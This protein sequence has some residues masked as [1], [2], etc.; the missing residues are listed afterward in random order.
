MGILPEPVP[1]APVTNLPTAT[2]RPLGSWWL[3][4]AGLVLYAAAV[5]AAGPGS[6]LWEPCLGIGLAWAAWQGWRLLPGFF[7]LGLAASLAIEGSHSLVPT[8]LRHLGLVGQLGVSWWLFHAIGK[9]RRNLTDPR[10]ATLFLILV[11]GLVAAVFAL[12]E[13]GLL[14]VLGSLQASV[15]QATAKTWIGRSLGLIALAPPLLGVLGPRLTDRGLV[16]SEG[17]PPPGGEPPTDWTWGEIVETS[18]LCLGAGILAM[19][20]TLLQV[21]RG[22]P[23]W[24]LWGFSLLLVV[25]ASV[26][27]GLRGG[28]LTALAAACAGLGTATLLGSLASEF[29]PLQGN[30]LA[31]GSTALLVGA[32]AGWIRASEARYRQVVGHIPVILYSARL[33]R[34]LSWDAIRRPRSNSHPGTAGIPDARL[35]AEQA[36]VT[37]VSQA[38]RSILGRAPEELLGPYRHW[39]DR[40]PEEDR[41]LPLA[42]LVQMFLQKQPVTA[43]YRVFGPPD[44]SGKGSLRWIR[45]TLTAYHAPNGMLDGWEGVLEDIT[46]QRA[47]AQEVRRSTGMLQGLVAN[48][49]T[50]VYFVQAPLGQPLL[51]NARARQLLGQREDPA[52]GISHL[53]RV[54]RLHRTDGSEYPAEELPI[55]RALRNGT[56]CSTDDIVV[57]RPDG[58]RV[59]LITWA[60]PV[61]LSEGKEPDAAVWVLE[62]LSTLQKAET[63]R[64]DSEARL[65]AVVETMAEGMLVLDDRGNILEGNPAAATILGTTPHALT[66]RPFLG[67][68]AGVLKEDGA[69]LPSEELPDRIALEEKRPVRQT[70]GLPLAAGHGRPAETRWLLVHALPLPTGNLAAG[71]QRNARVVVTFADITPLR[72]AQEERRR[73]HRLEL[74]GRLASGTMHDFN[75]LLTILMGLA[76]LARDQLPPAH[77]AAGELERLLEVGEQAGHLTGQLLAFSKERPRPHRTVDLNAVVVHSLKLLRSGIPADI[78]VRT[79]LAPEDLPVLA[80]DTQ[81]KQ[82]VMN[83]CLNAR[84]AMA[85]G[86]RLLLRT[87][88]VQADAI[89]KETNGPWVRLSVQDTGQGMD[90]TVVRQIFEPFYSTKERGTGLGLAVVRQILEDLAGDIRVW[91]RPGEGT[92]MDVFLP[93]HLETGNVVRNPSTE[94]R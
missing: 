64:R 5:L 18:G 65:R 75:N 39:L 22:V 42:T 16:P 27:Q 47:L 54:Y 38:C 15:L 87:D 32:S 61:F 30:I 71:F 48:L 29:S 73:T 17:P 14:A 25:W 91:S 50:G 13:T 51:V 67:R 43:E 84:D 55:A 36:Q 37:L 72:Q 8:V 58:R 52:A 90:D 83:L 23:G 53:P 21:D 41:E 19:V 94:P 56:A 20:L 45:E 57:H 2:A 11:P 12:V 80:D 34:G 31:Q 33:P 7:V 63:A 40:I 26:R 79:E 49:P 6:E 86:G 85:R 69:L 82:V 24:T 46:E 59:P 1:G 62:D 35:L 74:I 3:P 77:P 4:A 66:G 78:E 70:L 28:T 10:S 76:S 92:H 9:G 81:L 89:G 44:A 68:E 60:A 88:V 93:I